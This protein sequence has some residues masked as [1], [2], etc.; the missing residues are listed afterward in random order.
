M[1]VETCSCKWVLVGGTAFCKVVVEGVTYTYKQV[2][3]VVET[4]GDEV[5]DKVSCREE[6]VEE[7]CKQVVEE[8]E[9]C[10]QLDDEEEEEKSRD[11]H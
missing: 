1:V 2:E 11:T 10:S 7:T 6:E 4:C 3:V 5:G 8:A 9:T